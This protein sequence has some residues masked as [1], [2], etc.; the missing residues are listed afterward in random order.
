MTSAIL[1]NCQAYLWTLLRCLFAFARAFSENSKLVGGKLFTR[2]LKYSTWCV[3]P[4]AIII[5]N[6]EHHHNLNTLPTTPFTYSCNT[7]PFYS[8]FTALSSWGQSGLVNRR[9]SL[10][11]FAATVRGCLYVINPPPPNPPPPPPHP[12]SNA[13]K[14]VVGKGGGRL[15]LLLLL[16]PLRLLLLSLPPRP[17]APRE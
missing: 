14:R 6:N 8:V 10:G 15:L 12:Q 9:L 1:Y 2:S 3:D 7:H 4:I 13:C 16:L 11:T 17:L 5:F